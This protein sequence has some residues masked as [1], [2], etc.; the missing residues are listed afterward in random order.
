[1]ALGKINEDEDENEKWL[2]LNR[3]LLKCGRCQSNTKYRQAIQV[4]L[5]EPIRR[6]GKPLSVVTHYNVI[7]RMRI[8]YNFALNFRVK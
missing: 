7:L 1:M 3:F 2:I 8:S 5:L 4:I 6:A